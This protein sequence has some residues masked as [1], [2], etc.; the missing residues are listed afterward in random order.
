MGD[1]FKVGI[2]AGVFDLTHSGHLLMFQ[3][4]NKHCD[5]LIV[6]V[7]VDPSQYRAEKERPIETIYER[8]VRLESCKYVNKVIPYETEEDLEAILSTVSYDIRFVGSDH[9]G[10]SFTGDSI[11]KDTFHFNPRDHKYSS[12]SLKDRVVKGRK[13]IKRPIPAVKEDN[14]PSR[15]PKDERYIS[16][17]KML[18]TR[19]RKPRKDK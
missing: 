7:Q 16:V 15:I 8:F 12:S 17:D 9:E 4:A 3:Y 13:D 2:T 11:R 18:S 14:T 10:K 19:G 5:Y 6:C 1:D